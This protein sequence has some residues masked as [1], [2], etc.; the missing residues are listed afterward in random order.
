MKH[1]LNEFDWQPL[2]SDPRS[3]RWRNKVY[4]YRSVLIQEG[5]IRS[6]TP[7][8]IWGITDQGRDELA[9]LQQEEDSSEAAASLNPQD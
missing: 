4:W 8:G 7:R 9:R 6:D 1:K 5:L 2:P 3:V